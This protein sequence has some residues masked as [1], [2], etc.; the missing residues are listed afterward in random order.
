MLSETKEL[1]YDMNAIQIQKVTMYHYNPEMRTTFESVFDFQNPHTTP[2]KWTVYYPNKKFTYTV[3]FTNNSPEKVS[4]VILYVHAADGQIV[5][6]YPTYDEKKDIW[7]ADLDMGNRSDNYY[8]VNV[9]VDYTAITDIIVDREEVEEVNSDLKNAF[10]EYAEDVQSIESLITDNSEL[11]NNPYVLLDNL[12]SCDSY[13][14]ETLDSLLQIITSDALLDVSGI[15]ET[16]DTESDRLI[17]EFDNWISNLANYRD[18][19]YKDFFIN[20][21]ILNYEEI[22]E[23][24]EYIKEYNG[25]A[26]RYC[27]EK[28]D[29]IDILAL[30]ELG[31]KAVVL[32]DSTYIMYLY[33]DDHCVYIDTKSKMKYIIETQSLTNMNARRRVSWDKLNDFASCFQ[34]L[35][36]IMPDLNSAIN[37]SD[38]V[39]NNVKNWLSVANDAVGLVSCFYDRGYAFLD[40][41]IRSAFNER[42]TDMNKK[43]YL[44]EEN[45]QAQYRSMHD[46]ENRIAMKS[47][48]NKE[49]DAIIANTQD[50]DLISALNF[51]KKYNT[52]DIAE[53]GKEL[54]IK[55]GKVFKLKGEIEIFKSQK[56][57]IEQAFSIVK[58]PLEKLPKQLVK[59]VKIKGITL[60]IGKCLGAFGCLI[61]AIGLYSDFWDAIDELNEWIE[62]VDAIK[63]KLPCEYDSEKAELLY[64]AVKN[65]TRHVL[66]QYSHI[67]LAE[68]GAL[69]VDEASL[70]I[71]ECPPA[72]LVAWF[73]SGIANGYAEIRKAFP[74]PDYI[75]QR[76]NYWMVYGRVYSL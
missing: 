66:D 49:I 24:F 53:L 43:I 63:A 33:Q 7:V 62:L 8:P 14:I 34:S 5:P 19:L 48:R 57:A 42:I 28:L 51:E 6:L 58:K 39:V 1:T 9:S 54:R 10:L 46:I 17:D 45:L 72:E 22:T 38:D 65:E 70:F 36:T 23:D 69:Q 11:D 64:E 61:E 47:A 2:N 26:N 30:E 31:Y 37:G 21:S 44:R 41:K 12:L 16:V 68:W 3:D 25:F 29:D 35:F 67:L 27:Q 13:S 76:G 55:N 74:I 60:G 71:V 73:I 50:E 20:E 59:N 52:S 40:S 32:S 4:N 18:S 56:K 75:N 15:S